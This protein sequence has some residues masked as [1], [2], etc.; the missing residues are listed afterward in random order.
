ML[1][2]RSITL[3]PFA[4]SKAGTIVTKNTIEHTT[5]QRLEQNIFYVCLK[6]SWQRQWVQKKKKGKYPRSN[7]NQKPK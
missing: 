6:P 3:T 2:S 4:F 7:D 5:C 1:R